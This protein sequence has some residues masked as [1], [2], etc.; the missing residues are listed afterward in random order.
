MRGWP[1]R[2]AL[3]GGLAG[4]PARRG[5]ARVVGEPRLELRHDAGDARELLHRLLADPD[6]AHA[7]VEEPV[8]GVAVDRGGEEGVRDAEALLEPARAALA[9]L[10]RETLDAGAPTAEVPVLAEEPG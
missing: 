6:E 5:G 2:T 8:L 3:R 1:G 4:R 7:R 10:G 9:Q